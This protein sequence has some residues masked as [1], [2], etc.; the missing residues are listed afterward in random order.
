MENKISNHGV[1]GDTNSVEMKSKAI[2]IKM[3]TEL[4]KRIE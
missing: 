2:V 1:G 3:P 4:R